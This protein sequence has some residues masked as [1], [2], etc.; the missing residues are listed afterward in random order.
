MFRS[1]IFF[2]FSLVL[3]SNTHAWCG[4]F[5][6]GENKLLHVSL[7]GFDLNQ[8][9]LLDGPC[10]EARELTHRYLFALDSD[11][12][13][14]NFRA[15]A[16]LETPG[17]P[18]GSWWEPP[19]D[20]GSFLGFYLSAC[21]QMV[22]NTGDEKLKAKADAIV[23]EL[24]KCQQ[25]LG[26]EY[27]SGMGKDTFDSI[28]SGSYPGAAYYITHKIMAGLL[29]MYTL[30]ANKEALEIVERMANYIDKQLDKQSDEQLRKLLWLGTIETGWHE[31][32]GMPEVL[33]NLYSVTGNQKHLRLAQKFLPPAFLD[34][35]IQ[36]QDNLTLR[37]GNTHIP[38]I[39]GA[40]HYY[41]LTG[42]HRYR[43]A[44]RYFWE[45]VVN[46]RSYATGGTTYSEF[47]MEPNR[48]ADTL[49]HRSQ[50]FCCS[51]NMLKL[52]RHLLRW[53]ADCKYADYY[54]RVYFNHV[55]GNQDPRG[56]G[57]YWYFLPLSPGVSRKESHQCSCF[58]NANQ[59]MYGAFWCCYGSSVESFA[60]LADSIYFHDKDGIYVNLFVASKVSWPEKDLVLEQATQF[61][62]QPKTTFI[63]EKT[64]GRPLGLNLHIPYWAGEG[65]QVR[66]NGEPVNVNT[67][68]TSYL[69]LTRP[70]KPGDKVELKMPMKLHAHPMP[71]DPE[72]VAIM[73]GPVVLAGLTDS[74]DYLLG[75]IN[76]LESWITPSKDQDLVFRTVGQPTD[77]TFI[78]LN[79]VID[80]RYSVYFVVVKEGNP[81]HQRILARNE[82]QR[83]LEARIIDRVI[84]H[85][86]TSESA[87]NLCGTGTD[88]DKFTHAGWPHGTS[89]AY[90]ICIPDWTSESGYLRD[91]TWRQASGEGWWSWDL[92]VLPDAPIKLLCTYWGD[93]TR[94]RNFEILVE[95]KIISTVSLGLGHETGEF[96]NI[97][98]QVPAE[99]TRGKD[100]ATVKFRSCQGRTLAGPIF[101]CATIKV[102]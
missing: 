10:K 82:A 6:P 4:D 80:Q 21:A 94:E 19:N 88:S 65:V 17:E 99:L 49:V 30:C 72:L 68:T 12:L 3:I 66:L 35:L 24:A 28:E 50:E 102:E 32:G 53:T 87:H 89:L 41:E 7:K 39:V 83:R 14:F 75:D 90:K 13:L 1:I 38:V 81:R 91:K 15:N 76:N 67:S 70:W 56:M 26:G 2:W 23:T 55:L 36:E 9:A 64:D 31:F 16:K 37:H 40:A 100:K 73:Y 20:G 92:K 5:G 29:D 78:P 61:P 47:W 48:L 85:D 46:C 18:L 22:A 79:K 93:D 59:G 101:G 27:L 45:R 86:L 44:S 33:G 69:T 51:Y 57:L 60:K 25:A 96:F 54:E 52:T 42:D 8:V 58:A 62:R 98:Y 95:D 84:P 34:P 77:I 11:R 97:E 71:D 74:D 63:F 43:T